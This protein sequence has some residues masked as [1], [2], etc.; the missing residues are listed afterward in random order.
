MAESNIDLIN[1]WSILV[2]IIWDI[3][4]YLDVFYWTTAYFIVLGQQ[5][6]R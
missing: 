1:H 6:A 2:Q 5:F 4:F 3:K